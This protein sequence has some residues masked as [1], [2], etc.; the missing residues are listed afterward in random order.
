MSFLYQLQNVVTIPEVLEV[1]HEEK[2]EVGD[3][4]LSLCMVLPYMRQTCPPE[5]LIN[6]QACPTFINE[7]VQPRN[8]LPRL[9]FLSLSFDHCSTFYLSKFLFPLRYFILL[10]LF[11]SGVVYAESD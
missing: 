6:Q 10:L 11:G 8:H 2:N 9:V 1:K 7:G 5:S 4:W 3:I